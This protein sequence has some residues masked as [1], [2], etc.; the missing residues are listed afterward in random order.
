M[1]ILVSGKSQIRQ[2]L[3]SEQVRDGVNSRGGTAALQLGNCGDGLPA[4][5]G[6]VLALAFPPDFMNLKQDPQ[7]LATCNSVFYSGGTKTSQSLS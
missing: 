3:H 2:N 5:E 4:G 6:T 7:R 1:G